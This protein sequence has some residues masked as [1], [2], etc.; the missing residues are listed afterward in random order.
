VDYLRPVVQYRLEVEPP[1]VEA[2]ASMIASPNYVL[3]CKGPL[4]TWVYAHRDS[5]SSRDR[6]L[7]A[8]AHLSGAEVPGLVGPYQD[9][10]YVG[11]VA[12]VA[13]DSLMSMMMEG[14][15]STDESRIRRSVRLLAASSDKR[16]PDSLAFLARGFHAA[17]SPL[18]DEALVHC[19][20]R[21]AELALNT[22]I[23][24]FRNARSPHQ[25]VLALQAAARVPR[26]EAAEA[27]LAFYGDDGQVA[28]STFAAP[29][30]AQARYYGLWLATRV[31]EPHLAKWLRSGEKDEA[32]VA[33]ELFD[34]SLRYGP[35][36]QDSL[37]V[38]A[39]AAWAERAPGPM[40][41]RARA[42]RERALH[43][44]MPVRREPAV[45]Q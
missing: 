7:L 6:E 9:Q 42:I 33:L 2:M 39:L 13:N 5:L 37:V 20:G 14:G 40:A 27:L 24:S 3:P 35:A 18:L 38:G 25:E 41:K 22:F 34:R 21:C 17:A 43:P 1:S 23:G 29:G 12:L 16:A 28:D 31:A 19:Q 44:P 36:D 4:L 32:R 30:T 45:G 10:F 26:R 8:D 11:A 15:R